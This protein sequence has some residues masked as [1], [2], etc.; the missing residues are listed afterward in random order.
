MGKRMK[1]GVFRTATGKPF[2]ADVNGAYTI[3]TDVVPDAFGKGR[4]GVVGHPVGLA[5]QNRQHVA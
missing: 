1:R 5:L 2:N 4:A 3:V